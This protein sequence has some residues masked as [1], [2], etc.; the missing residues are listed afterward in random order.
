MSEGAINMIGRENNKQL[1][2]TSRFCKSEATHSIC[3]GSWQGRIGDASY[4]ATCEC[5]YH[6]SRS[7]ESPDPFST[8]NSGDE[9][10]AG[11][12]YLGVGDDVP[13]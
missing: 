10:S 1:F 5:G 6:S 4:T 2:F 12:Q 8:E 7:A 3:A 11:Q 9:N 13:R